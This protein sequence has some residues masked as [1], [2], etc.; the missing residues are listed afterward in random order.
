MNEIII[1]V[2]LDEVIEGYSFYIYDGDG[3]YIA[4]EEADGGLCTSTM[5]N[6]LDMAVEHAKELLARS[7]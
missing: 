5:E 7:K 3:A 2:S 4:C 1:R 6:A